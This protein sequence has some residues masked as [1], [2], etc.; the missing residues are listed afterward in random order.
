MSVLSSPVL[1]A[2]EFEKT[3][4]VKGSVL[5]DPF[6]QCPSDSS[7]AAP[8]TLLKVEKDIDTT[9]YLIP[10]GTALSRIVYQSEKLDGKPVPVSGF[11]LWPYAARSHPEGY[12]TVAWAHGATGINANHAPSNY[13]N[14]W[15]H[16]LAPYQLALQGYVVV[17]TD[18]AGLGVQTDASGTPI[19][20][21]YLASPSQGS[22]VI[23]SINAARTAFPEL[24]KH[25]VVIGHSQGGGAAWA[26]AQKAA[27]GHIPGYLGAIAISPYTNFLIEESAFS[28]CIGAAICRAVASVLPDFDPQDILTPEGEKCVALMFQTD[29]GLTAAMALFYGADLLKPDWKQNPHMQ[30]FADLTGN[31]GKAIQG[32]LLVIHG[33]ADMMTS[34]AGVEVAV[35]KTARLF[36]SAQIESVWL[37]D[38]RHAPALGASQRVWMDWIA[39]RFAGLEVPPGRRTSR[40]KSARPSTVYHKEK[41]WYLEPARQFYQ[42]I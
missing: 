40:L 39:D 25:F 24:S 36:P 13:K 6:Y 28:P 37:P 23:H 17:A 32:P 31:G 38:V 29:A 4:R 9:P 30:E 34:P 3:N 22:D 2:L 15:Q 7:Q 26:V 12:Q 14:L 1:E 21:E 5:E 11:I 27:A 18:Y 33:E 19:M 42:T 20:H 41:N 8:G 35:A 10:A 16:F